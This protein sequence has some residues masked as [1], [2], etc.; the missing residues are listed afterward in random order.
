M[1]LPGRLSHTVTLDPTDLRVL[2]ELGKQRFAF[3]RRDLLRHAGTATN[4][5]L[6]IERGWAYA[7]Q[8]TSDGQRQALGLHIPGDFV[9]L[10]DLSMSDALYSV[11]ALTDV[12]GVSIPKTRIR[13]L[14]DR[15]PNI[16]AA[17]FLICTRE[18]ALFAERTID[19]GRRDAY[20]RICHFFAETIVRMRQ[21]ALDTE[22][23]FS[24]PI[25]QAL[26][27]ELL[28]LSTVHV[29]R[30]LHRLHED[31]VLSFSHQTVE[32]LDADTLLHAGG[33]DCRY[34]TCP[35]WSTELADVATDT[36]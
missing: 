21:V 7:Y 5:L 29:N 4:D 1:D 11:E 19:L 3:R 10:L 8:D 35:R 24:L 33:F 18:Q 17:L 23:R 14:F 15:S 6:F 22:D 28:G 9:G 13:A 2:G 16:A 27:G 31:G 25:S 32:V 20:T 26:I 12:R 36:G 34:L 30:T